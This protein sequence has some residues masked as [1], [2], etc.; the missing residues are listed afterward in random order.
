V[1]VALSGVLVLAIAA[2]LDGIGDALN[3]GVTVAVAQLLGFAHAV[4]VGS[5]STVAFGIRFVRLYIWVMTYA[6]TALP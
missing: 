4:A 6:G 2:V 3:M 1:A 5:G